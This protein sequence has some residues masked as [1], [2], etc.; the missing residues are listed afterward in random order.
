MACGDA[1][2]V[3]WQHTLVIF[4]RL[5]AVHVGALRPSELTLGVIEFAFR[6]LTSRT[7]LERKA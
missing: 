3:R 4:S 1:R 7:I 5:L 2:C 6:M